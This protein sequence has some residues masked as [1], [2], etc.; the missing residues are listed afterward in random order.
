M[1]RE[2]FIATVASITVQLRKEGSPI[3]PSVRIAQAMLE[4]G[5]RIHEW[6]NLVGY[7][8]GSG[9]PNQFWKGRSVSTKTW[10]VYDG[11]RVDG[12]KAHWRAYD[13][14]EDCFRDQDLLF[15]WSHYDRVR[16]AQTPQEQT[17]MLRVCGYA[18]DPEYT[19]KLRGLI[20]SYALEQYDKEA[21]EPLLDAGVAN[22]VIKTWISPAWKKADEAGDENGKTYMIWL[23]NQLRIAS[24]Q[25]EQ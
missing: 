23:A 14:V 9:Q 10:E 12:V 19:K 17:E 4:T 20:A 11:V 6:N 16:A 13:C 24:G 2:E 21:A 1:T 3:F 18:T 7:K 25:P 5:G 22:T 8:V 15:Q